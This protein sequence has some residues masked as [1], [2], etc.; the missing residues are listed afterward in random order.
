MNNEFL[1]KRME[2]S[3][4]PFPWISIDTFVDGGVILMDKVTHDH[5]P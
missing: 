3:I 2:W 4:L 5:S 1:I